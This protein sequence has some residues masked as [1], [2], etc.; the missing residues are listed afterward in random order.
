VLAKLG[1]G[2]RAQAAVRA[3]ARGVVSPEELAQ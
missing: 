2:N 1:A 3:L